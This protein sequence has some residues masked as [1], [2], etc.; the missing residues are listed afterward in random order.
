MRIRLLVFA[1]LVL[2]AAGCNDAAK[3]PDVSSGSTSDSWALLPFEKLDSINPVLRPDPALT[4]ICPIR[5]QAVRWEEKD[6]FNPATV[7]R[8]DTLF[9]LYRA[10]DSIGKPSGTSRI[11]LAWS[12]DGRH[13]QKHPVPVLYPD[14]DPYKKWEW[15]GGCEDPRIVEDD[16]GT[17]YMTYTAFDGTLARL[18]VATSTDLY[19]WQKKGCVFAQ[20]NGGHYLDFWS[21]SGSIVSTYKNGKIIATRINGKYWMY[22]GDTNIWAATSDDLVNWTPVQLGGGKLEDTTGYRSWARK[23]P[24]LKTV[25]APRKKKFDSDLV[26]SG[27]PAMLTDSGIVLLYNSRNVRSIGDTSLGEGTYTA[28]Q[29]LIDKKDP[30]KVIRRLNQFFMQPDKPYELE[31]QVNRVCFL[32]GLASFKGQWFLYYGTADSKI[33][34]AVK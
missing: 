9:L 1:C 17:Y 5:R 7:V 23:A 26:E 8:R 30:T 6:V 3:R 31:G 12:T 20:A 25:I 27:P 4:F 32:E 24:E 33:A 22:W 19:H 2:F 34:L 18:L 29:V 14:N 15:E 10:Q 11:G 16:K 21:K 13:F 28:G